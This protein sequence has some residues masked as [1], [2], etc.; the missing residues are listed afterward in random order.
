MKYMNEHI[1]EHMHAHMNTPFQH[2][3]TPILLLGGI[4]MCPTTLC[5]THFQSVGPTLILPNQR[6]SVEKSVLNTALITLC[7]LF[8]KDVS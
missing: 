8:V 7:L 6:M 2:S 3:L 1:Y 5:G 4:H